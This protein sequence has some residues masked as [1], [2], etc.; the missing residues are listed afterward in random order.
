M[1]K[2]KN[3]KEFVERE[4][5]EDI[6]GEYDKDGFFITPNGSFWDPDGVYFNR[7]GYDRHGGYYDDQTQEYVPGKGWDEMNN[8]Y[9]DEIDDGYED[10]YGS[11][12]DNL[13]D[14]GYGEIDMDNIMDEEKLLLENLNGVEKIH[15]DPTRVVHK[16]NDE[17]EI[18]DK[19]E[20]KKEEPKKEEQKKD[21]H[22]N[23]EPKK[24]EEKPEKKKKSKLSRLFES[25]EKE[26]ND[27][28]EKKEKKVKKTKKENNGKKTT[29]NKGNN[30]GNQKK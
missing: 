23:E 6:E 9:K 2:A 26:K 30:R 24:D 22:K 7:E 25:M 15:E 3:A 1:E 13:E 19:L 17:N 8:C 29:N 18:Q 14:D 28:G 4:F 20:D 27:D 5:N 21:D 10:E 16:I 11:D 12:H